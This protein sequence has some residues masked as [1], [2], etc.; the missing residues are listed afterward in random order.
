MVGSGDMGFFDIFPSIFL[1][2]QPRR[3]RCVRTSDRIANRVLSMVRLGD[4]LKGKASWSVPSG[5][6]YFSCY[7]SPYGR[8]SSWVRPVPM[9]ANACRPVRFK[10]TI[11]FRARQTAKPKAIRVKANLKN[12][13][14]P[15]GKLF[16]SLNLHGPVSWMTPPVR[17]QTSRPI[18]SVPLFPDR[19][20]VQPDIHSHHVPP[21]T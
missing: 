16:E 11:R 14:S 6:V 10:R 20:N 15:R 19:P 9:I 2:C 7:C 1:F 5:I 21:R 3:P 18:G 8:C 17:G 12:W 13:R 4:F